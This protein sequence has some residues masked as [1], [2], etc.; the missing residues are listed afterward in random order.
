MCLSSNWGCMCIKEH[1]QLGEGIRW[2]WCWR[3]TKVGW[4]CS[5]KQVS[6]CVKSRRMASA[7]R[8]SLSSPPGAAAQPTARMYTTGLASSAL[9]LDGVLGEY[10]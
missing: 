1:T 5:N 9:R 10:P 7:P 8:S 4:W 3:S 2:K 6:V